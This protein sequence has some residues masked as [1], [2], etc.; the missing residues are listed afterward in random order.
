M[1]LEVSMT[2][3]GTIGNIAPGWS[4]NESTNSVTIGETGAGTGSVSFTA[5]ATDDSLL[6]INNNITSTIGNLGTIDGVVQSVSQSGLNA[7]ITHG[8]FLD[9]FNL[10]VNVPPVEAGGPKAWFYKL[11]EEV[12]GQFSAGRPDYSIPIPFSASSTQQYSYCF[13]FDNSGLDLTEEFSIDSIFRNSVKSSDG[14]FGYS[15]T[16]NTI[17]DWEGFSSAIAMMPG[18]ETSGNFYQTQPDVLPDLWAGFEPYF[19]MMIDVDAAT[20]ISLWLKSGTTDG[21]PSYFNVVRMN[22]DGLAETVEVINVNDDTTTTGDFSGL[23][24]GDPL[25]FTFY[26]LKNSPSEFDFN[27]FHYKVTN[28]DN[29]TI[30]GYVDCFLGGILNFAGDYINCDKMYYFNAAYVISYTPTYHVPEAGGYVFNIDFT[31]YTG[32]YDGAYPATTGVAWE[33]IQDLAAA[34]NFEVSTSGDTIFVRDIGG[35]TIDISNNTTPTVNPTSTLSG[36]QINI[37]YSNAAFV[38]GNIY[39]AELDGNNIISV[40]A[41]GTTIT[42]VKGNVDPL[43]IEQPIFS[44][45]WPIEDGQYYVI[46]SD[47]LPLLSGEWEAYGAYVNAI[48]DPE[49]NSAI[50]ITVVG[51]STEVTLAGGPYKLAVSDGSVEYAALKISGTGVY[52]GDGQ[53]QLIT[54]IDTAKYTRAT[55]NSIS[56]PFII[57]EE[58]AYDRGVWASMKASGPVVTVNFN[59]PSSAIDGVGLTPGALFNYGQSTYRVINCTINNLNVSIDAERHVL[60]ADTDA[61]WGSQT[62]ADFD[63]VWGALECQDQ[64]IFPYKVA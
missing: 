58:N 46:D 50:Q 22:I 29:A 54:A 39:D 7:N 18:I 64:I 31:A 25:L 44:E 59:I 62:V 33:L 55:V 1:A 35:A 36:S 41:G 42:T 34:E 6:V 17:P 12:F 51:P 28:S 52:G 13:P 27:R 38:T 11:G 2:G 45:V 63:A 49:D 3:T 61:I 4:F 23:V 43:S 15:F 24:N 16:A 5:Q 47:G 53:L 32:T 26:H 14:S 10:D 48:I 19:E 21:S 60:V 57:T 8:T 37:A 40:E 30:T 9:K 20:D 56:N